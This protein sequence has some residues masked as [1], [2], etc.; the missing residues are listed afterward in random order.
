MGRRG[1]ALKEVSSPQGEALKEVPR[2]Q[3]KPQLGPTAGHS[4]V[5]QWKAQKA[6]G[7][8]WR[9]VLLAPQ[10]SRDAQGPAPPQNT[11][12]LSLY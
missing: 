2:P 11:V 6:T 5:T 3:G 1:E 9:A 7:Q 8:R 12:Q 10:L 4:L